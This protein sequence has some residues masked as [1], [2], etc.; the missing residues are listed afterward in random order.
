MRPVLFAFDLDGT[1]TTREILPRLAEEYN[2]GPEFA[3]LTRLTMQGAIDF[4]ASLRLRF[5]VLRRTPLAKVHEIVS[6]IPLD[7]DIEAFI[8]ARPGQCVVI[9]GNVNRWIEPI[10]TRLGC[11]FIAS[12][13]EE[14]NGELRLVSIPDK[15]E[16]VRALAAGG[17]RVIAVGDGANDIPMFRAAYAGIAYGGV[18]TPAPGLT[19]EAKALA[20]NGKE[21]TSL[22]EL[23]HREAS[24]R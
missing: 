15:G 6:R 1:V 23:F 9:T 20:R 8:R 14:E 10:A 7:A 4:A 17:K 16:A 13:A 24:A 18:N 21:L 2:L 11:R 3:L 5:S 12:R 22:L 19:A